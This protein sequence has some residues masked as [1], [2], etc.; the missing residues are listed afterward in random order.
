MA[1]IGN[2]AIGGD[3]TGVAVTAPPIVSGKL[4]IST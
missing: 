4:K 2:A 1:G 3:A